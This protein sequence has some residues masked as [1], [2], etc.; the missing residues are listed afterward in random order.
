MSISELRANLCTANVNNKEPFKAVLTLVSSVDCKK[1][2]E[3]FCNTFSND[4]LCEMC[5]HIIMEYETAQEKMFTSETFWD[6]V[7][8]LFRHANFIIACVSDFDGLAAFI[9]KKADPSFINR[10][11]KGFYPIEYAIM[12][13]AGNTLKYLL[14]N[15]GWIF[16]DPVTKKEMDYRK[17]PIVFNGNIDKILSQYNL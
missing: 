8:Q 13:K 12:N 6:A 10:P 9:N 2:I 14:D 4:I 1:M 11:F 15:G 7:L 16:C 17:L 5:L 3:D